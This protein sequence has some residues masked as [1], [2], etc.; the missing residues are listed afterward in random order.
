M[1]AKDERHG[2]DTLIESREI[3]KIDQME[4]PT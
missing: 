4:I 1:A 3:K 2:Q